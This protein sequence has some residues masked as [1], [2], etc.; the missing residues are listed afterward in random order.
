MSFQASLGVGPECYVSAVVS[1]SKFHLLDLKIAYT[2]Q[3]CL[4]GWLF[5]QEDG[6]SSNPYTVFCT[7]GDGLNGQLTITGCWDWPSV[8]DCGIDATGK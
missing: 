7:D 3:N 1:R 5:E 6:R 8:T 2:G 4:F